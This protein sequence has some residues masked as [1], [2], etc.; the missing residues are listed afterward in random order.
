MK[1]YRLNISP[2]M[3]CGEPEVE[4]LDEYFGSLRKSKARRAELI[5]MGGFQDLSIDQLHLVDLPPRA[6]AL[7]VLNRRA[8]VA[9]SLRVVSPT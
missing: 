8:Y 1:V 4:D 6:L 5:R 3:G 2:D 7:R 9:E